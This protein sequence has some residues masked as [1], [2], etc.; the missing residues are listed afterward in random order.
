MR[1]PETHF[2]IM[3]LYDAW[4][5][6]SMAP[7]TTDAEFMARAEA[8]S[9]IEFQMLKITPETIAELAAQV[10]VATRRGAFGF[11]PAFFSVLE[12]MAEEARA[13]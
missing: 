8:L 2:H 11:E 10:V 4:M 9:A 12:L 1:G 7:G 6:L 13:A 3:P 5:R